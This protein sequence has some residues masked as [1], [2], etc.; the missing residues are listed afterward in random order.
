MF[1]GLRGGLLALP[2]PNLSSKRRSIRA[3]TIHS[4]CPRGHRGVG[5]GHHCLEPLKPQLRSQRARASAPVLP[6][7]WHSQ[8]SGVLRMSCMALPSSPSSA[9]LPPFVFRPIFEAHEQRSSVRSTSGEPMK[10]PGLLSSELH[11]W[12]LAEPAHRIQE[13]KGLRTTFA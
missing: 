12:P 10:A 5:H 13:V 1:N 7:T 2:V 8:A 11:L 6:S 3:L 9:S 4:S